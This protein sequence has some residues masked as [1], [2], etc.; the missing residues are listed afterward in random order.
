MAISRVRPHQR[1]SLP[2]EVCDYNDT[3]R[4]FSTHTF[5]CTVPDI[6]WIN[7]FFLLPSCSSS[8]SSAAAALWQIRASTGCWA[9]GLLS[10]SPLPGC[11]LWFWS[12]L[13]LRLH[14]Y[15]TENSSPDGASVNTACPSSDLMMVSLRHPS[16]PTQ[17][18]NSGH[19]TSESM[20]KKGCGRASK[21]IKIPAEI[22]FERWEI[23]TQI[24]LLV[25]NRNELFRQIWLTCVR[26]PK[27]QRTNDHFL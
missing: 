1:T 12:W 7:F 4:N 13:L 24:H 18:D 19:L 26:I 9:A 5:G 10:D 2:Y 21:H 16:S 23:S 15:V 20:L 17:E 14:V 11:V 25:I 3:K 6:S 27:F 22:Q 8:V